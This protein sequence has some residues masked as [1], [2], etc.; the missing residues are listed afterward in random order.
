MFTHNMYNTF[1]ISVQFI[2]KKEEKKE[3][4]ILVDWYYLIYI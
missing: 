4:F 2:I 1:K 3:A